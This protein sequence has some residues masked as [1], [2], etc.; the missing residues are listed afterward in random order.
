MKRTQ[1]LL[2]GL[3]LAISPA[4]TG[5]IVGNQGDD[6]GERHYTAAPADLVCGELATVNHAFA[7]ALP[8]IRSCM[9]RTPVGGVL[10]LPVGSY[11][12]GA[13]LI[14]DRA[15][16]VRTEA[17][18]DYSGRCGAGPESGCAELA[19]WP[20]RFRPEFLPDDS[21][22]FVQV[23]A[24]NVHLDRLVLNGNRNGLLGEV[25]AGGAPV[26]THDMCLAKN[27]R[28]LAIKASN[29]SLTRSVVKHALCNGGVHV[30]GPNAVKRTAGERAISPTETHHVRIVDNTVFANGT[31]MWGTPFFWADGV[32][33]FDADDSEIAF[34]S[35]LDNT[36]VQL[37]IGGCRRCRI[38]DNT[39]GHSG[40]AY[41][42]ATPPY[43][44]GALMIHAWPQVH[45]GALWSA[46]PTSGD[47]TNADIYHNWID[48]L[49]HCGVGVLFGGNPW[50]P[51][52]EID[53][54]AAQSVHGCD[55][56][57][58]YQPPNC[59]VAR[60]HTTGGYFHDNTILNA[61]LGFVADETRGLFVERNYIAGSGGAP[62][63]HV[64]KSPFWPPYPAAPG[65]P[66][67]KRPE[68][69]HWNALPLPAAVV[70]PA[71]ADPRSGSVFLFGF[72]P[73]I[74]DMAGCIPDYVN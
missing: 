34:N 58:W 41:G 13:P 9:D 66:Q 24:D 49:G 29:T 28:G 25:D 61:P 2:G 7:D 60:L 26:W 37:I 36:D 30:I 20:A 38:N 65:Q 17:S 1:Y 48:C 4:C 8:L 33:V 59:Y 22:G 40:D 64:T 19:P 68:C 42:S 5:T 12:L 46:V 27:M 55:N 62:P 51:P 10:E 43:S 74:D 11:L 6:D 72:Q 3:L 32:V 47:F 23:S 15:I 73:V 69:E 18:N 44:H 67:P 45:Y 54:A 70:S 14:L 52:Y 16:T 39:L 63:I 53:D 35:I 31:S 57:Q 71:S 56:A 21:G 50:Y